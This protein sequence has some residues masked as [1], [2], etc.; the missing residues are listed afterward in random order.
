MA[1]SIQK[2]IAVVTTC[3][4]LSGCG[5]TFIRGNISTSVDPS[6]IPRTNTHIVVAPNDFNA[7]YYLPVLKEALEAR[8]FENVT[9]SRSTEISYYYDALVILDVGRQVFEKTETVKDYGIV[10]TSI[11][12]G[13]VKCKETNNG[14][15]GRRTR[16]RTG[17]TRIEH[18]YGT[19][20]TREVTTNSLNRSISL[21]FSVLT[22]NQAVATAVGTSVEPDWKCS[23]AGIYNFL[24]IHT[25]K[26]IDFLS[27]INFDY[28]VELPEGYTCS[29]VVEYERSL[30]TSAQEEERKNPV[31]K[32]RAMTKTPAPLDSDITV[33]QYKR[34]SGYSSEDTI[35]YNNGDI[36]IGAVI[37]GKP[38]GIGTYSSFIGK[39][40]MHGRFE[41][42]KRLGEALL[43]YKNGKKYRGY[44]RESEAAVDDLREINV[45]DEFT[46]R[47]LKN[48]A[49]VN[50]INKL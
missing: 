30:I 49:V 22:N 19:T 45:K 3:V 27:P 44:W 29:N 8:G 34:S 15:T 42:G 47:A 31:V 36:Y 23:N 11:T 21:S 33:T 14:L 18:K 20:G 9:I 40:C 26:R 2:Y 32:N 16:C 10:G 46:I 28:S 17:E 24:I 50:C 41:A 6:F 43:L 7:V 5:I 4:L 1:S 38:D 13:D 35:R 12:P 39:S 25:I 37:N 48:K